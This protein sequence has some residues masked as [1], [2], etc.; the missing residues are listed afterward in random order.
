[1][2]RMLTQRAPSLAVRL[3]CAGL[4][5]TG[6]SLACRSELRASLAL[7]LGL[8]ALCARSLTSSL[9][10]LLAVSVARFSIAAYTDQPAQAPPTWALI[11]P[12]KASTGAQ[13]TF[14]NGFCQ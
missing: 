2:D 1:M 13:I 5:A 6:E 11:D 7:R 3:C 4:P 9:C 8:H 12:T 10:L 14:N